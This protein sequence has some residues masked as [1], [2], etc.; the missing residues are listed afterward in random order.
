[1]SEEFNKFELE[2]AEKVARRLAK[3]ETGRKAL[4][5]VFGVGIT[6]VSKQGTADKP[7]VAVLVPSHHA[8]KPQMTAAFGQMVSHSKK[9][10]YVIARPSIASSVVHWVRNQLLAVLYQSGDPFTHVLFIDDDIV[11]PVDALSVM[12][13]RNKGIVG[14]ACTVRQDPPHPNFRTY[15]EEDY[16]FKT[17]FEWTGDG[18]MQIGAVG[19]GMML[20]RREELELIAEYYLSCQH[21]TRFFGVSPE[22][23]EEISAKRRKIWDEKREA[24]WFEFLKHPFGDGEYGE[25]ISFCFKAQQLGIPVYV[26]TTVRPLHIGDYGYSLSDFMQYQS[27]YIEWEKQRTAEAQKEQ[28]LQQV[29]VI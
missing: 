17:V 22:R 27:S 29:E 3:S 13:S 4:A 10:C 15:N 1:M 7:I 26:D 28:E 21:E 14:A 25:D 8:P 19:T 2:Q 12:L 20:I 24:W 18:C 11:P 23:A 5:N 6:E 16:T 9:D